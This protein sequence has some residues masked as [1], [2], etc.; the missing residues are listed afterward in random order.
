MNEELIYPPDE[1]SLTTVSMDCFWTFLDKE[2]LYSS[3]EKI[4]LR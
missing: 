3:K 2:V 4:L 1:F